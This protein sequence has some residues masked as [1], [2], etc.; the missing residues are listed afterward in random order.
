MGFKCNS[1]F[2]IKRYF[3]V[4][5][6]IKTLP[7]QAKGRGNFTLIGKETPFGFSYLELNLGKSHRIKVCGEFYHSIHLQ[8]R[9]FLERSYFLDLMKIKKISSIMAR[10]RKK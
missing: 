8:D 10:N 2:R 3:P 4:A 9:I 7:G 1:R 5:V 6:R